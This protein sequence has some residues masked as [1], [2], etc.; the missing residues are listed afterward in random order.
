MAHGKDTNIDLE[1][2]LVQVTN[3]KAKD[4]DLRENVLQGLA[5]VS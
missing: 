5:E 4:R 3:T 1:E 2:L